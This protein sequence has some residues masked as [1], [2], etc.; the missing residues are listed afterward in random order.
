MPCTRPDVTQSPGN[1]PA[2]IDFERWAEDTGCG[3]AEL[4]P[5]GKLLFHAAWVGPWLPE[6]GRDIEALIDSFLVT[7]DLARSKLVFWFLSDQIPDGAAAM[8]RR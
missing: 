1:Y 5:E 4:D 2:I 6:F 7:Q 3:K 8:V